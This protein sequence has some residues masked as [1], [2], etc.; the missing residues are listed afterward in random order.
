M[1]S[2]SNSN[3]N[4]TTTRFRVDISEL[5]KAMQDAK[6]QVA[7]ANSEFKATSS[8]LDDWSKSAEGVRAKLTQLNTNLTA[9]RTVLNQYERVLAEIEEQY[10]ENSTEAQQYQIRLNNQRAVV[11]NLEREISTYNSRLQLV[12]QAE[13]EAN[14]TGRTTAEV[15]DD[16]A[17]SVDDAG[18]SATDGAG[19][20][21]VMKGALASL[22]ADAIKGS[23]QALK[24]LATASDKAMSKLQAQTG[25]STQEMSK[26]KKEIEDLYKDNY[27]ESLEDLGDK[28]AYIKQVTGETDPSKIKELIQ[29]A[30]TLEDTFGSDFNETVRG[31]SN[32]MNHFGIDSQKA[33]D[34]FAKG[35]Q[36]GL[37]YTNELGDNISEY[38]GK[39]AEAGYSAEEYFQLLK[40]GSQGGAYNLDKVNDA[41]NE[42]TTRMADGTIGD[43][44]G[45]FSTKTQQLFK[46][47]KDGGASQK[48]VIDSIVNDIKNTTNEQDKMN[49]SALA[50]G[51]M[52][53]DGGTKFIESLTSVG[54]SFTDT[55]GKMEEL[56][57][58]RYDNVTSQLGGI[59]RT[60]KLELLTPLVES[61]LPAVKDAVNW[62]VENLPAIIE[63]IKDIAD[64]VKGVINIL[65]TLATALAGLG[66]ATL[67]GNF[68][69]VVTAIKGIVTATKLWTTA[70]AIFNAVMNANPIVLIITLIAT[71]VVSFI[72]AYKTSETFRNIVNGAFN[73]IKEVAGIV[74]NA[75]VTFF[76][77]TIPE[78]FD[79]TKENITK[80]VEKIK[81]FFTKTIPE[82]VKNFAETIKTTLTNFVNNIKTFFTQKIPEI[83]NNI[84]QWFNK[85]PEK[86]GYALGLAIGKMLK[87]GLDCI[88][89]VKK[90]VPKIIDN[91]VTFFKQL[92]SKI[93]T[94]LKNT[95]DK[96]TTWGSNMKE[97]ATTT[98]KNFLSSVVNTIK[99]LPAN[100]WTWLTN[101]ISKVTTWASNMKTKAS[102]GAKGF[103]NNVVTNIKNLPSKVWTW[104]SNTITKLTTWVGNMK[105]KGKEAISGLINAVITGAKN[106]PS[107]MA[108]IGKNIVNGV[109]SG[110]KNAKDTFVSNVK[111]FFGGIVD[112][113][114]DGLGIH[115][116]SR[117]FAN[118]VGK[119]IPSGVALGI[120]KNSNTAIRSVKNLANEMVTTAKSGLNNVSSS[121]TANQG[122]GG[123]IIN[124]YNQTINSPKSLSRLEIYRQSK[125]LLGYAGGV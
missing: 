116:P 39:F 72:T 123:N 57:Q 24:N 85:L 103:L 16:L 12:E 89:F 77:K 94:W 47:W 23:I 117:V 56:T 81:E 25:A 90:E 124:N 55:K 35:S 76:T 46:A 36:D 58:V 34:L 52:G 9:Q 48:E 88:N 41:I 104:L 91:I 28:F 43:G 82:T 122:T 97:K 2:N 17:D 5:K 100:V 105:T 125:N 22:V 20:F 38:S 8:A 44:I 40:N 19:G 121:L 73:K 42:V 93:W 83:I 96:V 98:A 54:D 27:G 71:L 107:Q 21:T 109:W 45:K 106:I 66:L 18:D 110:I 84:G 62:A 78:A 53:E 65:P 113:V 92:P 118:E 68:T 101:T 60:I 67:I 69:S 6:R 115:S 64:K 11:N 51:T 120:D 102:E 49:L 61:L 119:Y 29:N 13:R 1:P 99:N 31:V 95:I 114:K 33:F 111:G 37:D 79:K 80:L 108:T 3:S 59:G 87:W 70:Q 32:L 14:R 63:K 10:G 112:G 26:F 75:L 7:L 50:F 86:I 74:V 4:E 15:F 30:I